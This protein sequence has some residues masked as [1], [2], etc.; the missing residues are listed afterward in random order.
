MNA[1]L[2]RPLDKGER[3]MKPLE[4]APNLTSP[5]SPL[6]KGGEFGKGEYQDF[7]CPQ[8]ELNSPAYFKG[9]G[10]LLPR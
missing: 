4:A 3:G 10:R 5:R 6:V 2:I 1:V 7:C 9:N 8:E